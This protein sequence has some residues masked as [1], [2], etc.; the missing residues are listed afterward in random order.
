MSKRT[1]KKRL[2]AKGLSLVSVRDGYGIEGYLVAD[3][4]TNTIITGHTLALMTLEEV[5]AFIA[6]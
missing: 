1:T 6:D 4:W 3:V 2:A 5:A